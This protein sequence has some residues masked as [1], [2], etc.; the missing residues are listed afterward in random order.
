M[1]RGFTLIELMVTVAIVGIL[2]A[3]SMPEYSHF[4]QRA[5]RAEIPMNLDAIRSVE[6]GYHAEWS[7]YTSC[8]LSPEDV[9]G[10][11]AVPFP[12]TMTTDLDW[13]E[14]GWTPDG[15]VFGQYQVVANEDI[16]FDATMVLDGYGD[17]DGDGNLSNYRATG[18][19]KPT[20]LTGNTIY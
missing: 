6:V 12:A 14:L 19:L 1:T 11:T 10:R 17:I 9:P 8:T 7:V 5:K 20:L 15:K 3:I 4:L 16:G 2:S 18:M 13:N